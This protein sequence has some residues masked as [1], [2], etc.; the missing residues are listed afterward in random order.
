MIAQ[1]HA[2]VQDRSQSNGWVPLH[3]AAMQGSID[4]CKLLL[5]YHASMHPRTVEGDTPRDLALRYGKHDVVEF[6]G[7]QSNFN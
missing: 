4:C 7:E 5:T 3:N 2:N 6:L 1:G